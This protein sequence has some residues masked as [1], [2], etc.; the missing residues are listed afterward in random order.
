MS[1]EEA[2]MDDVIYTGHGQ[3]RARQRGMRTGDVALILACATQVDD[4]TWMLRDRDA[5]R[6]IDA[7]RREI[8]ALERLRNRKIVMCGSSLVTTYPSRRS[9]QKRTLRRGKQ[10][11]LMR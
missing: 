11:G 8:Q 7:R 2:D 6:A 3:A 10:K 4:E 1:R 5:D 9:D